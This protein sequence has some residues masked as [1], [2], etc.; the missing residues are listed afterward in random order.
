LLIY[1]IIV[2][3]EAPPKCRTSSSLWVGRG[4]SNSL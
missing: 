2:S 3:Q 1:Q 4:A